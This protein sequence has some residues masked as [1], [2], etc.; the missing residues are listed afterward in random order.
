MSSERGSL[1]IVSAASGSGKSTLVDLVIARLRSA[2]TVAAE[3]CITCTTRR[4]RGL[5]R[6][7]I[8]YHFLSAD[9][10]ERRIAAGDLLE[11]ARVHGDHLYGTSRSAVESALDR[12]VTLLLV[13]DVQGA[14][15]VRAAMPDVVSVFIM[16]PSY[17]VLEERLRSRSLAEKHVDEH[18]LEARLESA[19]REVTRYTEFDYV[20]V[21]DDRERAVDALASI[22][23]AEAC[24]ERGQRERLREI[25]KSFETEGGSFHAGNL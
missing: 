21:N 18:D 14:A 8:D 5:E 17:E 12:G 11:Y 13:I 25:V 22:V 9:E 2:G 15:S 4:P 3:R 24:R 7:G 10:F 23:T 6:D 1:I 20:I 16:P 19:R